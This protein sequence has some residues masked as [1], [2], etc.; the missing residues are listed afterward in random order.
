MSSTL[1]EHVFLSCVHA[2]MQLSEGTTLSTKA[3]LVPNSRPTVEDQAIM[4][5]LVST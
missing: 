2:L 4:L 1:L 3:S 5:C